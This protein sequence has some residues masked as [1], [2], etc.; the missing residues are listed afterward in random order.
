MGLFV[1]GQ[2]PWNKGKTFP[3]LTKEQK[4]ANQKAWREANKEVIYQKGL[5]WKRSNPE[6][7]AETAKRSRLKNIARIYA[8][9]SKRRSDRIQRTPKWLT[10]D[11]LWLIKEAHELA[12]LR[13][14]LFGFD[15]HV[16]HII[17]LKGKIVS[18]LHVPNNL[19]VIEGKLNMMKN[20][21]FEGELI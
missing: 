11:E 9:N 5:E 15:W 12:I 4:K 19:Q 14:K 8:N 3:G 1:K 6:R 13:T 18:G 21:K 7:V 20:N 10:K 16:D 2:V 17:P